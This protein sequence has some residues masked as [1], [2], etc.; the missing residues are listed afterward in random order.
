MSSKRNNKSFRII[1]VLVAVALLISFAWHK[2]TSASTA[3]QIV[4]ATTIED[5]NTEGID[6]SKPVSTANPTG[7]IVAPP[8]YHDGVL[9]EKQYQVT[10]PANATSLQVEVSGNQ[11]VDLYARKNQ[12]VTGSGNTF[13]A[14]YH[15]QNGNTGHEIITITPN[16]VGQPPLQAGVYIFAVAN[17]GGGAANFTLTAT[18]TTSSGGGS[19]SSGIVTLTSGTPMTCT[20]PAASTFHNGVLGDPQFLIS[21]PSG[22]T[23]L[24]ISVTANQDV[25]LYARL[26]Q[27]V[28][29]S[30]NS[31]QADVSSTSAGSSETIVINSFTSPQLQT[32]SYFIGV[33]NNAT[34]IATYTLTATITGTNPGNVTTIQSGVPQTGTVNAP[35]FGSSFVLG[36]PQ[37]MIQVPSGATQLQI[38]LTGTQNVDLYARLNQQ[39]QIGP[40]GFVADYSAA[41]ASSTE[42]LTITPA[43]TPPLQAGN[44]FIAVVNNGPSS[45]NFTLT[46][47]INGGVACTFSIL[48][49][50]Q[51]FSAAGGTG[52]VAVTTQNGC[53]WTAVS[54]NSFITV[55]SG[56]SGTGN[57]TVNYFV[58]ANAAA[59]TQV[60]TITIAGQTFT[61]TEAGN[62]PGC[63]FSIAPTGQTF[64]SSGGTGSVT[65][66]TQNGCN[67]TAISNASFV[68]VT[69]G[70]SGVGTGTVNYSVAANA[71][72]QARTGT[73]TIAGQT[74]TVTQSNNQPGCTFTISPT[75]QTF[76]GTG[77]TGS[78]TV[79]TQ[80][81][82]NWTAVSNSGFVTITSGNSG[83]GSGTV[84]YSVAP[85]GSNLTLFGTLTIAGQTFTVIENPSQ[86]GCTFTI[87]PTTQTFNVVGGTGSVTVTT[88]NGCTWTAVSN[89]GFITITSGASGTGSGIVNYTVAATALGNRSGTITIAGQTFTVIQ[90]TSC[91]FTISPTQHLAGPT[92]TTGGINVTTQAGCAWTAGTNDSF[93]HINGGSS[94]VGNG[95]VSYFLDANTGFTRTGTIAVAGQTFTII[96]T[97]PFGS[98]SCPSA[99]GVTSISPS[100]GGAGQVIKLTGVNFT[101]ITAV[102]FGT[103]PAFFTI[104]SDTELIAT[105]PV[106]ATTGQIILT[107]P[108][109]GDISVGVFT[110]MN[111]T[112][113]IPV[114]LP[115][116]LTANVGNAVTVPLTVGDLTG[117]GVLS[118]DFT[119]TFDPNQLSPQVTPV[120]QTGTLSSS[121]ILAVNTNVAGQLRVSA[122][123]TSA[124]TGA[125]TLLNLKFNVVG[126]S[127]SCATLN[128]SA[129][130]F[131]E[132]NPC[133]TTTSGQ[134][135]RGSSS[136]SGA[137]N[138]AITPQGVTGVTLTAAG[139]PQLT[140]TTG[141]NGIYQF[142]GLGTGAYTV[143]PAKTGDINSSID[144]FDASLVLRQSAGLIT[145]NASQ[146]LAADA[147][148]D[149]TVSAF[150]AALIAQFAV[151]ISNTSVIGKW[152][153]VPASRSYPSLLNDQINQNYDAILIGDVSG[154]WVTAIPAANPGEGTI[155][156]ADVDPGQDAVVGAVTASLPL[157]TGSPDSNLTVPITVTDL[158]GKGIF[159][160]DIDIA[161][162]PSVLT[163][164]STPVSAAGTLSPGFQI[165]TNASIPGHL[166]VAAFGT[167]ALS[168]SGT[169]LNINFRVAPVHNGTS[170]LTW[171]KMKFNDGNPATTSVSGGF[172][173]G[174]PCGAIVSPGGKTFNANGGNGTLNVSIANG[175][176]IN[177]S[178][179]ANWITVGN[180]ANGVLNYTV[181][182]NSTN[183][184]RSGTITVAGKAIMIVQSNDQQTV[185]YGDI[186][187]DGK[188]D[189]SDLMTM[190]NFLAGNSVIDTNA[191]D[192]LRDGKVNISDLMTLANYLAGNISNLPVVP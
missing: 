50:S 30:G 12:P 87:S 145:L 5:L 117:K 62:Q 171:Q 174:D 110:V 46:A 107:K 170:G 2:K 156:K 97:G 118:Y 25:D 113:T 175:C 167:S 61:V 159:S 142:T 162:D 33:V 100:T 94:G 140:F 41:T 182:A 7:F 1:G 155:A 139:T 81:G 186:N 85:S 82:C 76:S 101:G 181:A 29:G 151:G 152:I 11:D 73:I 125:G 36:S 115:T 173:V 179:N 69:S 53:A 72:N 130:K 23:Q 172:T 16:D 180:M 166:K 37:F 154:N 147:S 24:Q 6:P 126:S 63:T 88:Q 55:T 189:I 122:A 164:Q 79:T 191:A 83:T 13:V 102:R 106:G 27:P 143:T 64:S 114:S 9:G 14:D 178:S 138:Y 99:A 59:S 78:V 160:Y 161:F 96:Q 17:N 108:N 98:P 47:T 90:N 146:L 44:Y 93:I 70:A 89:A 3:G 32:G 20:I 133:V 31:F 119:I 86:A 149:G 112:S 165:V 192:V 188:V 18:L 128:I 19:C 187:H 153:F 111:C 95:I 15:A 137:V 51:S 80:A 67:W 34:S 21:V 120:D 104:N 168:G 183:V 75:S 26:N 176:P 163:L 124:L 127:S 56:A 109:C 66:T 38:T 134:V 35:P 4:P 49:T 71:T 157:A 144:A 54:N 77:G 45:A 190:A 136:I 91:T 103:V 141:H 131:N 150:D 65:V 48:P 158:S 135:C 10:V 39:V 148:G 105:V 40:T 60:G 57:G 8:S 58:S 169:L 123:S 121:V 132:G 184:F 22:A 116:N 28:T 84:T 92:V 68:T 42:T 52:S 185:L 129:F 74:F 43:S 177:T